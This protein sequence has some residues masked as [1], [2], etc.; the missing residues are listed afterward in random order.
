MLSFL[1][2]SDFTASYLVPL[3]NIFPPSQLYLAT[4]LPYPQ[5]HHMLSLSPFYLSAFRL[6]PIGCTT[7]YLSWHLLIHLFILHL[8]GLQLSYY[9]SSIVLSVPLVPTGL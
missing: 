6:I 5:C 9:S 4:Q 7:I 2:P 3:L 1:S 8:I